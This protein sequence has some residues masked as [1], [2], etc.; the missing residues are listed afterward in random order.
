MNVDFSA[1]LR[2]PR[3]EAE[4]KTVE[5]S[6]KKKLKIILILLFIPIFWIPLIIYA[7]LKIPAGIRQQKE[8][9]AAIEA[10]AQANNFTYESLGAVRLGTTPQGQNFEL[11]YN[12]SVQYS[13]NTMTG[14]F[15]NIPFTYTNTSIELH[16]YTGISTTDG[17]PT[18]MLNIFKVQLPI[19]MPRL[20]AD[21]KFNNIPGFEVKADN[22][23]D[24]EEHSLEGDFPKYYSVKAERNDRI[25]VLGVLSPEVMQELKQNFHYDLWIHG[26]ELQLL[27]NGTEIEYFA[28]IPLVFKNAEVLL[29][30]IDRIARSLR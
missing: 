20:F 24:L 3:Y 21:S 8:R 15:Q 17:P 4:K 30:E 25:D 7:L 5:V 10:F 16:N 1:I 11:P 29:K 27:A 28:A 26:N 12:A 23:G 22:F 14:Q 2:S 18:R 13:N 19:A 9:K 6:G